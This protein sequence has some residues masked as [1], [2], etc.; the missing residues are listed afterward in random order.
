LN[1]PCCQFDPVIV[2]RASYILSLAL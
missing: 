2:D 1:D